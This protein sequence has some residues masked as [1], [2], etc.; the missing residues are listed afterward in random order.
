MDGARVCAW[1]A[2]NIAV[3]RPDHGIVLLDAADPASRTGLLHMR[4]VAMAFTPCE[5]AL[6]VAEQCDRIHRI[7]LQGAVGWSVTIPAM[8]LTGETILRGARLFGIPSDES[9]TLYSYETGEPTH[10]F[11]LHNANFVNGVFLNPSSVMFCTTHARHVHDIDTG[12]ST[13]M[14]L[15]STK[16]L[17]SC[18][19]S[20]PQAIAADGSRL[21]LH[22]WTD[23]F[24]L[25]NLELATR[26]WWTLPLERV[27]CVAYSPTMPHLL[28]VH[29][30]GRYMRDDPDCITVYDTKKSAIVTKIVT[31]THMASGTCLQFSPC[32]T[33]LF[34]ATTQSARFFTLAHDWRRTILTMILAA[35]RKRM[36]YFPP[37]L[38]CL[39]VNE[40]NPSPFY[41]QFGY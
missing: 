37:E 34:H 31:G 5:R 41:T 14:A 21:A 7:S 29:S 18:F 38:W 9:L 30:I 17:T 40:F 32:G 25:Y 39:T 8:P 33:M 35:R 13:A 2:H 6:I 36:R 27:E 22:A 26:E 1:S 11:S 10:N 19:A 20:N 23:Q 16:I 4:A 12:L 24:D 3:A 28:A 15:A